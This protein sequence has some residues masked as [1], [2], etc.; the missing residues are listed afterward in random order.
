MKDDNSGDE[1]EEG[2]SDKNEENNS[3]ASITEKQHQSD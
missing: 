3:E 2:Q 1:K